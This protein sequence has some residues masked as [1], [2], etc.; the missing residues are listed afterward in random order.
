[1]P[2]TLKHISFSILHLVLVIMAFSILHSPFSILPA[3]ADEGLFGLDAT[4][5]PAGLKSARG[6]A[7]AAG[8]IVGYFLAFIGV[9]FFVLMVYGGILW[10]TARG[11]EEMI[12]KAQ[13]L[14]KSAIIGMIIVFLSYA[15]T[16]FVLSRLTSAVGI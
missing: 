11:S 8:L 3:L 4:A 14:I 2:R 5:G 9:V 7:A 12:K 15:V 6:P 10:M 1:M 16:Q 13:E